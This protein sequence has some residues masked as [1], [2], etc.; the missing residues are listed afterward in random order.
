[1]KI[2]LLQNFY[3]ATAP[4]LLINCPRAAQKALQKREK[5]MILSYFASTMKTYDSAK[6]KNQSPPHVLFAPHTEPLKP[7]RSVQALAAV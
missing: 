4:F 1:M 5:F 6:G 3:F 2:G 7:A